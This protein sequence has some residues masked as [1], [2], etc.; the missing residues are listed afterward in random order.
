MDAC[1]RTELRAAVLRLQLQVRALQLNSITFRPRI[2][3]TPTRGTE[4]L[5]AIL[6][7]KYVEC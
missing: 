2:K 4:R 1:I 6:A 5:V 7:V 3:C